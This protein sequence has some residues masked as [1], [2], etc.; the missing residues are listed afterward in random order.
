MGKV[1]VVKSCPS[2]RKLQS[3]KNNSPQSVSYFQVNTPV[4]LQ[5]WKI[6]LGIELK[7]SDFVCHLHFKEEHIKTYEKFFIKGEVKIFPT[8]KKIVRNE[9]LPTT[10]HQFIPIPAYE[11]LASTVHEQ[12]QPNFHCNHSED[13]QQYQVQEN[14]V[15][16]QKVLVNQEVSN[17]F[18]DDN[19]QTEKDLDEPLLSQQAHY[20][21]KNHQETE[22]STQSENFRDNLNKFIA[23]PP[24][25]MYGD[26][27]NGPEFMRM[28]PTTE[29]ITNRL[30]LNEDKSI[31]V[32]FRNNEE[33]ILNDKIDSY[34]NIYDYLKSVERWPLCVGTQIDSNRYSKICKGSI[35]GDDAYI[36]NQPNPRCKSCRILRN[37]L[38]NHKSKSTFINL[39]RTTATKRRASNLVKQCKRLKLTKIQLKDK[40]FMAKSKCAKKSEALVQKA[41]N[42]L[43]T[44]FQNAVNSCFEA[45]KKR[46]AKGR[47]YTL[48]WIYECI[49]IRL[50]SRNTYQ[51][52]RQ[53]NILPLP[54]IDTLNK[55]IRKISCSA[56]GFQPATF[57]GLKERCEIMEK[58]ERRGVLLVDEMKLSEDVFFD[59]QSMK[60]CGFVDLGNHTPDDLK[61]TTADHA[62]VFK[63]V[64]FRGR[65]VQAL[66]CFLSKNACKSQ[67]LHKLILE[68]IVLM[69]NSGINID[70]VVMDGA[71]WNRGVWKIFGIDESKISCEHPCDSSRRL[72]M[73]SDFHHLIKCFRTSTL[74]DKLHEFK[75]P[76]GTVKKLHW[77][78]VLEEENYRQP[79]MKIA[80]KLTPA[81]LK[82]KGFQAMNV[83]LATQVFDHRVAVAMAHF[84]PTCEKLKDSTAT[85]KFIHLVFNLIEAMSSRIPRDALFNWNQST[86]GSFGSTITAIGTLQKLSGTQCQTFVYVSYYK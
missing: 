15:E 60:F 86:R 80:Y 43:P 59:S 56:Y 55:F 12:Q 83:P 38:Q 37:R 72:W 14:N 30:R 21:L 34:S 63:F 29:R 27:P 35:V 20:D 57:S 78:A 5:N 64:P 33:L 9:A 70:A 28:D 2:G 53:R 19:V 3:T 18:M 42:E 61:N 24:F 36:R 69:E 47:R 32:I 71:S 44:E 1:C 26:K 39:K 62:L 54:S 7:A 50:K 52:L 31:T 75:T 82:P 84:Q 68:C 23:L 48:E 8:G 25:W 45:A 74:D 76:Y 13:E 17:N 40:I 41:I 85:Q 79:N 10:E 4:R 6:S 65:W 16:Q 73:I 66:G 11:L 58:G 46:N 77:E 51:F 67:P 49:L 22:A 81:H